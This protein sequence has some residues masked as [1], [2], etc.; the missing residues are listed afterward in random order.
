MAEPCPEPRRPCPFD[1][2]AR[3]RI[4]VLEAEARHTRETLDRI[5]AHVERIDDKVEK[6]SNEFLAAISGAKSGW[7]V[8]VQV[9]GLASMFVAGLWYLVSKIPWSKL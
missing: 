1:G 7:W 5:A 8:L 6:V 9:G 3:E 4:A 2:E